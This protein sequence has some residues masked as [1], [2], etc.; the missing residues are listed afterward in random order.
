[1]KRSIRFPL[2]AKFFVGCLLLAALLIIGGTYVIKDETRLR[3]RGNF[4]AKSMRRLQGSIE[5]GGRA[6]TGTAELLA[7]YPD[8]R[9][10]LA[11]TASAPAAPS[12][13]PAPADAATIAKLMHA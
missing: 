5:Q 13:A 2:F 8:L 6:V 7:V 9:A 3:S 4:L 10:A 12:T 11:N 1:M